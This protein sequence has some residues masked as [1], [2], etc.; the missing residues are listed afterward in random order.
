MPCPCYL[1]IVVAEEKV[2]ESGAGW[3]KSGCAEV[4]VG[5]SI[6]ELSHIPKSS[7]ALAALALALLLSL[8]PIFILA[9]FEKCRT[10]TLPVPY[11]NLI[12]LSQSVNKTFIGA[13]S[14]FARKH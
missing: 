5:R 2:S 11:V 14:V 12:F 3:S 10:G 6:V 9:Y 8:L 7:N 4:L 13:G 1:C